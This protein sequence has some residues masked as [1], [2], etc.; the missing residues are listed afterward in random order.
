MSTFA[1]SPSVAV[2]DPPEAA[3][4]PIGFLDFSGALL[5]APERI[6]PLQGDEPAAAQGAA[7]LTAHSFGDAARLLA[8]EGAA[9]RAALHAV[10]AHHQAAGRPKRREL[11]VVTDD[12]R[13]PP[14]LAGDAAVVRVPEAEGALAAAIGPKTAGVVLTPV[15]F[16]AGRDVASGATLSEARSLADE[17]GIAL[18]FDESEAGLGRT[19][20]A[21]AHEWRGVTPDLMLLSGVDGAAATALVATDR[22]A[23]RLPADPPAPRDD[24]AAAAL[25]V[26]AT[27]FAPGFEARVQELGWQLEDRL[28]ALRWRRPDLFRDTLGAGLVQGLLCTGPAEPLKALLAEAGLGV[29]AFGD[30]LAIR[31]PLTVEAAEIAAAADRLDA[32]VAALEPATKEA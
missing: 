14:A 23:R 6:L 28:A 19:G 10:R 30:I 26:L 13:L 11:L 1:Q 3:A 31:P 17:Y 32:V 16:S 20:M 5:A 25:G 8:D 29:A 7:L 15:R 27:A 24:V 4:E 2:A 12:P 21:F 9:W 18:L 22:F